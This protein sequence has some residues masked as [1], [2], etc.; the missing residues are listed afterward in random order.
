MATS[1]SSPHSARHSVKT[2]QFRE[3]ASGL[4]Y[5]EGPVYRP[6]GSVLVVEISKGCL[7]SIAPD[8]TRSVVAQLGG[9]PNGAAIGPDGAVYICNDGGFEIVPIG[10]LQ[11]AL[12]QPTGYIGGSIQR[13][14]PDGS[15]T[16]LYTDFPVPLAVGA[17]ANRLCSPDDLVFDSAGNFWFTDWGKTRARDRDVTGVYYA[18]PDGSSIVEKVFP[19]E[20]PNG[21]A[22]SPNEDRLYVAES[23][24]RR[25]LYWELSAPGTIRPNPKTLDGSYLLTSKIP[26]EGC[27]DSMA[28]DEKGNLYVASFLPHGQ[29]PNSRGGITVVSPEA[30]ILEWIE[31]DIGTPDP[32]PS[33]L[34]FGGPHR[35]TM[36]VTLSGTGRLIACEVRIPGKKPAFGAV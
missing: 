31:I 26:F 18:K 29:D 14:A 28:I 1:A 35:T 2:S 20:S 30:E 33:N 9:G 34:C 27:L 15:F 16:T 11:V 24:T 22:L 17:A 3:I 10:H 5:P 36:Y 12:N 23:F 32:F 25:I 19:L 8:G 6:D 4:G 7:S 21:I 13:V